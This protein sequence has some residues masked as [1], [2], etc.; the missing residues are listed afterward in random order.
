MCRSGFDFADVVR[1]GAQKPLLACERRDDG[2]M[3]ESLRLWGC[4]IERSYASPEASATIK[5][6][7]QMGCERM[8]TGDVEKVTSLGR[9]RRGSDRDIT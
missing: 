9:R 7:A 3:A 4:G 5:H 2:I 1:C 8:V 6:E